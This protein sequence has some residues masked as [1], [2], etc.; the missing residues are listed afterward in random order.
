LDSQREFPV[1]LSSIPIE[2]RQLR[3]TGRVG[4]ELKEAQGREAA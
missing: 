2:N 4:A 3:Y 1:S